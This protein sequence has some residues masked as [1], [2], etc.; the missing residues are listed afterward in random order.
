VS[1]QPEAAAAAAVGLLCTAV[2][3]PSPRCSSGGMPRCSR[4]SCLLTCPWCGTPAWCPLRDRW[5]TGGG[6]TTSS[7]SRT[8]A[9]GGCHGPQCELRSYLSCFSKHCGS[10]PAA[11]RPD[12]FAPTLPSQAQGAQQ[13]GAVRQDPEQHGT[14]AHHAGS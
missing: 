2:T 3:W 1:Q 4:A 7:S 9:R 10:W 14:S 8:A 11:A 6:T 5:W 12:P 13:A